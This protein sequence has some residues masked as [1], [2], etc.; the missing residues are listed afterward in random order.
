MTLG[1]AAT[2]VHPEVAGVQ[3]E[4]MELLLE[5]G[6][7]IERVPG[8]AVRGCLANGRPLAARFLAAR[9]AY[10]DFENAAGVGDLDRVKE[11]VAT[12][13]NEELGKGFVWACAYGY[14]DVV[15]FLLD[16]GVDP[17]VGA[18]V[19]MTGLHLAAHE[20]HL[21]TVKLLLAH[22]APLEAKNVYGGTVLGQTL[23][24][25]I[26]HPMPAH[27]EIVETLIAA[28]AKVGDDWFT[29]NREHRRAASPRAA[30]ST[31]GR[32]SD[33]RA[34]S[35]RTTRAIRAT[36]R[37]AR[38][39]RRGGDE[40]AR[41]AARGANWSRRSKAS[42]R[43]IATS[44]ADRRRCRSTKKRWPSAATS[45][46]LSSSRTPF[47]TSAISIT[48][49]AATISPSRCTPRRWRCIAASDAPPLDLANALRSLAVIKDS[50]AFW[51]E[52]FHL[53]VKTNVPPGVAESALRLAELAHRDGDGDR[54][55]EWLRIANGAAEESDDDELRRRVRAAGRRSK[56]ARVLALA[57]CPVGV[58]GVR[59]VAHGFEPWVFDCARSVSPLQRAKESFL[60]PVKTGSP[61]APIVEPQVNRG[62]GLRRLRRRSARG[63]SGRSLRPLL[64]HVHRI[65]RRAQRRR[66]FLRVVDSP[67]SA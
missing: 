57:R 62:Y 32:R 18:G 11:L 65:E 20:G 67:R 59:T 13:S 8:E 42:P 17:A 26:H 48:T 22:N 21:D 50:A 35:T 55:R 64:L 45:A 31:G 47:A 58:A 19:D 1:L 14:N 15:A 5:R 3:I 4:L 36:R 43:S 41:R 56:L 28:G 6:A 7:M 52:A 44:A 39:V 29:G 25:V 12:T 30:G 9:G 46:I 40:V 27:R 38:I 66:E 53:Y 63:R 2:S 37:S 34:G 16:Y 23:W 33:P 54:A 51:E 24:S 10:L 49:T 60:S 61:D